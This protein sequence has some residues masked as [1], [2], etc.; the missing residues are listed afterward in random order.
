MV[1]GGFRRMRLD[2]MKKKHGCHVEENMNEEE[3]SKGGF[4]D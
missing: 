3:R 1:E 2:A 4:N